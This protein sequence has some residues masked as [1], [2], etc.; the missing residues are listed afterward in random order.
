MIQFVLETEEQN[1]D[2]NYNKEI[3]EAI[4]AADYVLQCLNNAGKHLRMKR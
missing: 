4:Q 3:D 2:Y 1:M